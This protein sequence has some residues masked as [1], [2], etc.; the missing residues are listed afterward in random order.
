MRMLRYFQ[1]HHQLEGVCGLFFVSL[2]SSLWIISLTCRTGRGKGGREIKP[3]EIQNLKLEVSHGVTGS[4]V[5]SILA[6]VY[7]NIVFI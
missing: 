6:F 1:S 3:I 2:L 7:V 4:C 5:E